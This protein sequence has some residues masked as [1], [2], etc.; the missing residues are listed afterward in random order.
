M[1]DR[2]QRGAGIGLV[3]GVGIAATAAVL[4][5]VD[6][7]ATVAGFGAGAGLVVGALTGRYA[8]TT[9][10]ETDQRTRV[11]AVAVG[12]GIVVGAVLG[13]LAAWTSERAVATFIVGGAAGGVVFGA[14]VGT[15][16]LQGS[17]TD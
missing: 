9:E 13:G 3:I 7:I 5:G 12:L 6:G 16:L 1:R 14:M 11:L 15:A 8:D 10:G 17:G 2:L 4:A